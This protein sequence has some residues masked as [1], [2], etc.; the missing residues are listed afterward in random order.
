[1]RLLNRHGR[2]CE[3]KPVYSEGS[4]EAES[5]SNHAEERGALIK[6]PEDAFALSERMLIFAL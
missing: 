3:R 5:M 6:I 2:A 1:M 4:G